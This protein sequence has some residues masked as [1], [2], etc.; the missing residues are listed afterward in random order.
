MSREWQ[1]Y[2]ALETL[3]ELF[4]QGKLSEIASPFILRLAAMP[5]TMKLVLK[6]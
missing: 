6:K 2:V 3:T 1:V 4:R 5:F